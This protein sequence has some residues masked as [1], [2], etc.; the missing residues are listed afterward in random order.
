VIRKYIS[1]FGGFFRASA[2]S[3]LEYRLNIIVKVLT[4]FVWYAAQLSVFEVL[5]QN[6]GPVAGWDLAST[7]V[8]MGVLFVVDSIWM[9]LLSEN[10]DKLS[11]RVRKGELDL[12]LS[13]PVNSQFMMSFQKLSTPYVVNIAFTI[14]FLIW[15]FQQLPPPVEPLRLLYLFILIPSSLMITYGIRFFFSA[16]A[17]IFARAENINYI[18]YQLYRIAMRPDGMYPPWMRYMVLTAVPMAFVASVPTRVV[19]GQA[20]IYFVPAAFL[21]GSISVYISTRFWRYAL[22]HY[23][24]AS[25]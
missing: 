8:F 21:L 15:A 9:L 17:L 25:S 19:L 10:L 5:F 4:D 24:S 1:I 14:G 23:V 20:E 3:D 13:K 7:R 22:R 6:V 12:L 16:T 11:D 18:W 2:I